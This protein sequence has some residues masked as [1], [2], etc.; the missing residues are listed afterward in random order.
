MAETTV[1][2]LGPRGTL[3]ALALEAEIPALLRKG[4][5]E[6]LGASW[7]SQVTRRLFGITE[8]KSP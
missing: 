6:T 5:L 2:L 7:I 4:A 3:A 8:E 1:G